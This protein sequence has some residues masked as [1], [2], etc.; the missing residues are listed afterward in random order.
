MHWR[1]E[2][3]KAFETLQRLC[4][5]SPFFAY[6]NLKAPF[7][8]HTDASGEGLSAVLYQVK[9]GKPAFQGV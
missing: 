4:T 1:P 7:N 2:Q 9:E 6:A 5:E 3:E 8:L